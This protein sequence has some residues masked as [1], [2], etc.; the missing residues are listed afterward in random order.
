MVSQNDIIGWIVAI[1]LAV[2]FLIGVGKTLRENFTEEGRREVQ[3]RRIEKARKNY[4]PKIYERC[5]R[6][7]RSSDTTYFCAICGIICEDCLSN[8]L[9]EHQGSVDLD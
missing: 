3:Q 5:R 6:C 2:G 1:V 8:C 9:D 7:H 4:R